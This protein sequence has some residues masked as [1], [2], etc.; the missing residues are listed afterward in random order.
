[1]VVDSKQI[2]FKLLKI[3][4]ILLLVAEYI[5]MEAYHEI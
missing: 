5:S 2:L 1:M 4:I 3:K